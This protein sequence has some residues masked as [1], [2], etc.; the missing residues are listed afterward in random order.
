MNTRRAITLVEL[1]ATLSLLTIMSVVSVSWMTTVLRAQSRITTQ[2][3]WHRASVAVLDLIG[4][5]MITVDR[6]DTG[7]RSRT[8]RIVVEDNMLQIRS[9]DHNGVGTKQYSFDS[10]TYQ[11]RRQRAGNRAQSNQIALLGDTEM[12]E[13]VLEQPSEERAMPVLKVSLIATDGREAHRTYILA[14][15]DVQ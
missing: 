12:F 13:C 6:L 8:P 10:N 4:Q 2:A 5:D 14:L 15:E 11:I 3:D 9:R 1:L 7:G